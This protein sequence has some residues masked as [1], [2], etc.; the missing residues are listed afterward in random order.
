MKSKAFTIIFSS[1]LLL[2]L[3]GCDVVSGKSGKSE[4][5]AAFHLK[6]VTEIETDDYEYYT[7]YAHEETGVLYLYVRAG[8]Y[9]AGMT[10]LIKADG[11]AYTMEDY[12]M[13]KELQY[14][15]NEKE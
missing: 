12:Y 1:V 15:G 6:K 13:D 9:R 14:W 4:D 3:S 7:I 10:A 11:T 8:S 2:S 5:S